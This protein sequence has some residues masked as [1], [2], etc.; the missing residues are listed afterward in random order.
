MYSATYVLI[1][2]TSHGIIAATRLEHYSVR[3]EAVQMVSSSASDSD[4][5]VG[6]SCK[7]S[8]QPCRKRKRKVADIGETGPVAMIAVC[9]QAKDT[10]TLGHKPFAEELREARRHAGRSVVGTE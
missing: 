8:T 6:P 4:V 3:P 9:G 10:W 2:H 5:P 1:Q 7:Q